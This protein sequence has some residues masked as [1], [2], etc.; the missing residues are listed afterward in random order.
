MTAA[1]GQERLD[2]LKDL[3][4][5]GLAVR[6][7]SGLV[8]PGEVFVA[9]PGANVDGAAFIPQALAAGAGWVVT[10][11]PRS[12]PRDRGHDVKVVVHSDPAEALG[13]L[14]R[15]RFATPEVGPFLIGVT[16][17]NGKTSVCAMIEHLLTR[18]GSRTG[19]MGTLHYRWPGQSLD[20][21]L[22]TPD[23]WTLHEMLSHMASDGVDTVAMEVSSHALAQNRVAGL[24]F[25]MAVL[26][27]VSQ[28]HLDYHG[29][30]ENYYLAKAGLF[31]RLPKADKD[32]VVNAS[33]VYGRRLLEEAGDREAF[34]YGL[35]L[36]GSTGHATLSGRLVQAGPGGM[37]LHMDYLGLSWVLESPL[38]GR[39][40]ASN[41]LAAQA[42]GLLLGLMP[43]DLGALSSFR[44]APGRLE[45]V[46]NRRG[47][48]VFVDY[49]HT[50]D[51]LENVL[52]ALREVTPGRVLA[53]FGC[54][55]DRDRTKRPL[56]G[57]AVAG[58]ADV[59]V[60]TSDN[61]RHEDP[62]DIIADTLPGL[63][64]AAEALVEPDRAKAIQLAVSRMVPGDALVIAGKGHETYQQIGDEKRPFSDA[65]VAAEMLS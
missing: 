38:V 7:H 58:L 25:D 51:A 10:R 23:C 18:T 65:A 15:A 45:R 63:A 20:A 27:S 50:P 56:M 28:D 29:E 59:A 48:D 34:A 64:D 55:G 46:P 4:A 41:L 42:V 14:A 47:L 31:T 49:A 57:R 9:L 13:E 52:G 43:R 3:V 32:W 36:C 22:T 5:R 26:T 16:G 6:T 54:G 30:M 44:G 24:E 37:Q 19:V 12:V 40:N 35:N 61:P 62:M 33:D 21:D 2:T 8:R 1:G 60:L 11:D 53:V 17:T 39:H